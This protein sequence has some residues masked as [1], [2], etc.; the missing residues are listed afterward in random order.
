MIK[1]NRRI[2]INLAGN[3][4]EE[5]ISEAKWFISL[6]IKHKK[7]TYTFTLLLSSR[8]LHEDDIVLSKFN[9]DYG[10]MEKQS[11]VSSQ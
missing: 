10:K 5:I 8:P 11:A 2:S 7:R 1:N 9:T 6:I 3:L 4:S